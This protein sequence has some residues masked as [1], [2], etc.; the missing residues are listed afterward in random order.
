MPVSASPAYEY[1]VVRCGRTP[2]WFP[3]C[4]ARGFTLFCFCKSPPL[5]NVHHEYTEA[6]RAQYFA[7][8]AIVEAVEKK[9]YI[10]L[11]KANNELL[12]AQQS[13]A[14]ASADLA[15][16]LHEA[17]IQPENPRGE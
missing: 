11:A 9:D 15:H 16:L 3:P 7:M 10:Q 12:E 1:F 17:G 6:W 5:Q 4:S 13:L 8:S 2:A 14:N